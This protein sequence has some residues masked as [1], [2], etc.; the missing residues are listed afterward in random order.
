MQDI[1]EWQTMLDFVQLEAVHN[2][3]QHSLVL[4][5]G[6]VTVI[7][8]TDGSLMFKSMRWHGFTQQETGTKSSNDLCADTYPVQDVM[9][10]DECA[11]TG[12]HS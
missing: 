10:M 2:S 12:S 9:F 4:G 6:F 11:Q 8:A 3:G 5:L 7:D 1:I